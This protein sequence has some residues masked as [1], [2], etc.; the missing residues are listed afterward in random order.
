MTP[1]AGCRLPN[2]FD[3]DVALCDVFTIVSALVDLRDGNDKAL[4]DESSSEVGGP[5]RYF[6]DGDLGNDTIVGGSLSDLLVGNQGIDRLEG[7]G[8]NDRLDGGIDNDTLLGDNGS[9]V[10]RMRVRRR[11]PT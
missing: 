1:G 2:P 4:F 7:R 11:S 8:G 5:T 6:I 10:I 3:D 9:E